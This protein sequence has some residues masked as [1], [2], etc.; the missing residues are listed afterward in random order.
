MVVPFE[1]HS[2]LFR[3]PF[4]PQSRTPLATKTTRKKATKAKTT[5]S[6][7]ASPEASGKLALAA[8]Q[9]QLEKKFGQ[10][11]LMNLE[12]DFGDV[13][14]FPVQIPSGSLAFDLAVGPVFRRPDGT[15]QHGFAKG[16]IIE[17]HGVAGAGKSTVAMQTTAA[18]QRLGMKVLFVDTEN[19]FDPIYA[20]QLGVDLG[21]VLVCQ[22]DCGE[23][24]FETIDTLVSTGQIGFVV[25]DSVAMTM[26][27]M[28]LESG[29]NDKTMGALAQL[30]TTAMN[31]LRPLFQKTGT[32]ALFTNHVKSKV[33]PMGGKSFPG[34]SALPYAAHYR[35]S[36]ARTG[37][38]TDPSG[39]VVGQEV[40]L[41]TI[42][43]KAHPPYQK[44]RTKL[45]YGKGTYPPVELIDLASKL[46]VIEKTGAWYAL[47]D[48][49]VQGEA[50][51]SYIL[52]Q[53]PTLR[54]QIY[55]AT[56]CAY[57][58]QLGYTPEGDPLPGTK[59]ESAVFFDHAVAEAAAG[60]DQDDE[61]GAA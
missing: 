58:D 45:V 13:R 4:T 8:A 50:A 22:P 11:H 49:K 33:G 23:D 30:M 17:L 55:D 7:K 18:A 61:S 9:A 29:W 36:V 51:A 16:K 46:G 32:T 5:K 40:E 41:Q 38:V 57:C 27:R 2:C 6:P 19:A 48:Q 10:G 24:A 39:D 28:V 37:G 12:K 20:K 26:P 44:V 52:S 56:L 14:R 53:D 35:V 31:K 15:W 54:W 21:S 3:L 1:S 42:K 43:N 25:L 60:E 59:Q 47:G 34:G